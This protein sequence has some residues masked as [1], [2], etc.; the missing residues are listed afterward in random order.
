MKRA[1]AN[2]PIAILT[3]FYVLVEA[4]VALVVAFGVD[5]TE[6]Q[7]VA[8]LMTANSVGGLIL[9][10]LG[11]SQVTPV[12]KLADKGRPPTFNKWMPMVVLAVLAITSPAMGQAKAVIAGPD[13]A[14]AGDLVILTSEGSHGSAFEWRLVGS[15]KSFL[16]V[17][18]NRQA[19][20][21]SGTPGV[22]SFILAVADGGE[23]AT[24]STAVHSVTIG[25]QPGPSPGPP[26]VDP[27]PEPD[28]PVGPIA[29]RL[30]GLIA[31]WGKSV[32]SATRADE[33][34]VIAKAFAD[35][36]QTA[37]DFP[38]LNSFTTATSKQYK[39]DLAEAY[40]VAAYLPWYRAV[41]EPLAAELRKLRDDGH[42]D[43]AAERAA[44]WQA[45]ANGFTEAAK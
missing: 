36:A 38:D 8:I 21:A 19:V 34:R 26:P 27:D 17:N 18:D 10:I 22:Y 45:I 29:H 41:F 33:A 31:E 25:K 23:P 24:V 12:S 3:A 15:T 20:F 13:T 39:T 1:W 37:A 16:A 7:T 28:P 6:A 4:I 2:E 30:A 9:A 11:R 43:T 32:E 42:L 40:G 14:A 35:H 44:I 5:L